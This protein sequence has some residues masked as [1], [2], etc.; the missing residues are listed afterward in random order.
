MKEYSPDAVKLDET[1]QIDNMKS[2]NGKSSQLHLAGTGENK[3]NTGRKDWRLF[4]TRIS[5]FSSSLLLTHLKLSI[6]LTSKAL[7]QVPLN[8]PDLR[9]ISLTH[10]TLGMTLCTYY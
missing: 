10:Y 6:I 8:A 2:V 4:T 3:I 1:A 7:K 5:K 9:S